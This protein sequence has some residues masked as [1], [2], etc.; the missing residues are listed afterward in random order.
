MKR[1]SP[2]TA[3]LALNAG[4]LVALAYMNLAPQADAQASRARG[5]YGIVSGW[6]LGLNPGVAYIMDEKNQELVA[7]YWDDRARRFVG[8]GYRNLSNDAASFQPTR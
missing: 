8:V 5:G 2:P 1:T 4:L 7:A 3:L 6:V